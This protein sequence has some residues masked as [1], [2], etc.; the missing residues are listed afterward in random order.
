MLKAWKESSR[1][2][3]SGGRATSQGTQLQGNSIGEP[4]SVAINEASSSGVVLEGSM[5]QGS[6][7][8]SLKYSRESS[9][10][11]GDPDS[12]RPSKKRNG[13]SP[14]SYLRAQGEPVS[15]VSCVPSSAAEQILA[16][17]K[18]Q[19][20][21]AIFSPSDGTKLLASTIPSFFVLTRCFRCCRPIL[22]IFDV[23]HQAPDRPS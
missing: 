14:V 7:V 19:N 11:G 18:I 17:A 10:E 6:S 13:K 8:M 21:I 3:R 16:H 22:Q 15:E 4:N 23:E 5:A 2:S 12:S 9:N 20:T 1:W